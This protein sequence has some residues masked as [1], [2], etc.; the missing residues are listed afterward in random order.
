MASRLIYA[1]DLLASLLLYA[2]VLNLPAEA[3]PRELPALRLP[4]ADTLVFSA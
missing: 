2:D 3:V 4:G 1:P